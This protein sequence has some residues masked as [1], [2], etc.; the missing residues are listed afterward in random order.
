MSGGAEH[1]VIGACPD[2]P[3][4]SQSSLYCMMSRRRYNGGKVKDVDQGYQSIDRCLGSVWARLQHVGQHPSPANLRS[5]TSVNTYE[6]SDQC[7][8]ARQDRRR[9]LTQGIF[10]TSHQ[11]T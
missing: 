4:K 2:K 5:T 1:Y 8:A 3:I 6:I 9:L 7:R 10:T 11:N